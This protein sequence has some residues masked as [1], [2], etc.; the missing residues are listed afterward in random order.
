MSISRQNISVIIVSFKS[1]HVIHQCINSIDKDIKILVV[2]NSNNPEFKKELEKK[3]TN[4]KCIL[5]SKNIGMGAGNNLGIKHANNDYAFI[6]NPD[7][8]L[9][10]DAINEIINA[11]KILDFFGILAPISNKTEYPNYK[12]DAKTKF[13][14]LKPFHVKSVDGYA[15][16]LNLKRLKQIQNFNFFDENFFLYLEN[17]DLCRRIKKNNEN[18]FIIPTSKINHFGGKAVDPKYKNEIELSRNW[19]WM[20]S[21]F[22]FNKKH[23]GYFVATI[24][25]LSNLISAQ[26]KFLYYLFTFNNFKRKIYQMRLSGLFNS[27]IGK[28]SFYRPNLEN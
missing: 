1:D 6:L 10:N 16:L 12:L 26:I 7:V 27:M 18:I 4:V 5:S 21:K 2:D 22:Y 13:D 14:T 28:K 15:M 23:F 17:D 20:W 9:D 19:H 11:S 25:I 24:S 3:Y 8:T